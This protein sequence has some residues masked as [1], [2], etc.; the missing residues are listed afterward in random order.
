MIVRT[1][2]HISRIFTYTKKT[3]KKKKRS[4]RRPCDKWSKINEEKKSQKPFVYVIPTC[5][6]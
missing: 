2:R 3:K 6:K 5:C 4:F 1:T